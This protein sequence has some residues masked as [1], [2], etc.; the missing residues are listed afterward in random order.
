MKCMM[1]ISIDLCL[2]GNKAFEPN[3]AGVGWCYSTTVKPMTRIAPIDDTKTTRTTAKRAVTIA[4]CRLESGAEMGMDSVVSMA[5]DLDLAYCDFVQAATDYR[6]LCDQEQVDGTYHIVKGLN[7]E[8]YEAGVKTLYKD[9]ITAYRTY[10][11]S[12]PAHGAIS[13]PSAS[14]Q[15][16]S[17]TFHLKK[18]DIP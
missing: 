3:L 17:G 7:L 9:S 8:Q 6:E 14:T 2:F 15:S 13:H 10:M 18:R 1:Y 12:T 5:K 16:V 4:E 11:S